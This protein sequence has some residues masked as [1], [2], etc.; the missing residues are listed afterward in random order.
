MYENITYAEL[1]KLPKEQKP[2]AWKELKS[3]YSSTKELALRLGVSSSIVYN[4]IAK[5]VNGKTGAKNKEESNENAEINENQAA[6]LGLEKTKAKRK[7]QDIVIGETGPAGF[8]AGNTALVGIENPLEADMFSISINKTLSGE[9][10]QFFLNGIGNTLLK[11]QKYLI[12]VKI[13][14]K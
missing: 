9:D 8:A 1:K 5:Y 4:M 11:N 13:K 10:A 12:E 6:S 14:E 2:E 3:L 7:R